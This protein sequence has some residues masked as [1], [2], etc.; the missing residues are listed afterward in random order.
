MEERDCYSF[1]GDD[2]L[3]GAENYPLCKA[4]VNHNQ[5][6]IKARGSGEVSDEV[7]GGLLEGTGGVR[8]NW[9]E[10]RNGGVGV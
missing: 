6:R 9:G 3:C 2:F 4:M 5:Q 8:L 7:T 10:W 1:G